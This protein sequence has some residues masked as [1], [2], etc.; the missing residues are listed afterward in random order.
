VG[1]GDAISIS[2]TNNA[3]GAAYEVMI[4]GNSMSTP[5]TDRVYYGPVNTTGYTSLNLSWSNYL[6]H[7]SSSYA[8]GVRV[9]TSTDGLNWHSTSWSTNPVTASIAIGTLIMFY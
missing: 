9:E 5:I 1:S 7:Y 2:N 3:G 6:N 8:Y 4:T